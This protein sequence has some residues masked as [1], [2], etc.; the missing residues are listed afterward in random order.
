VCDGRLLEGWYL[1]K[2]VLWA[3]VFVCIHGTV[4]A[5]GGDTG[6]V[7]GCAMAA[8]VA[9]LA[10]ALNDI[11]AGKGAPPPGARRSVM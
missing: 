3:C 5:Q 10:R 6:S 8:P 2:V 4:G 11:R 9:T 1:G 7:D